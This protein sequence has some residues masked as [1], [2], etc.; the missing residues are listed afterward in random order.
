MLDLRGKT[1]LRQLVRLVYHAQGILCPVTLLMHL[2]AA[3]DVK[4]GMP[5]NRACVVIAGG[6]EP[7]QWEAYPHH[8]YIHTN[9]ALRCCDNGGCWKARTVPLG[10]GD[11]KDKPEHLCVDPIKK[12]VRTKGATD[13]SYF[14]PRCMDMITSEEVA[15]RVELYFT[16]GALSYLTPPQARLA[17]NAVAGAME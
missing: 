15:R 17:K 2:A 14:L 10:D 13:L 12:E 11:E 5:K 16:G 6:R 9:G 7:A 4:P 8:Q 1:D 3:V